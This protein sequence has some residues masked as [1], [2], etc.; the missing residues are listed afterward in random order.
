MPRPVV[1]FLDVHAPEVRAVI[2]AECPTSLEL[3][4]A[5]SP[6]PADRLA[7][8]RD[9]TF[10]VGGITPIPA[11]LMDAAPGLRL[12]QKWG[13]GVPVASRWPSLRARTPCPWPSSR[14]S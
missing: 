9:A 8:A 3:R 6:D 12:I 11:S 7:L 2:T 5:T 4:L 13:I 1:V 14:C 10:F